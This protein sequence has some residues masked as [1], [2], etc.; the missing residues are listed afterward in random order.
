M[1]LLP[2]PAGS[3]GSSV[4]IFVP[5]YCFHTCLVGGVRAWLDITSTRPATS[6]SV[7]L[8]WRFDLARVALIHMLTVHATCWELLEVD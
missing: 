8:E 5:V 3:R 1:C 7:T 4:A 6:S 2:D